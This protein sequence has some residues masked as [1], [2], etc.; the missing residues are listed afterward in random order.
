MAPPPPQS[1]KFVSQDDNEEEDP[2]PTPAA[3]SGPVKRQFTKRQK[4]PKKAY[5]AVLK[6]MFTRD[7]LTV[8]PIDP[9]ILDRHTIVS[10]PPMVSVASRQIRAGVNCVHL[11]HWLF[12][13][14]RVSIDNNTYEFLFDEFKRGCPEGTWNK[15]TLKGDQAL[16]GEGNSNL[17]NW[18]RSIPATAKRFGT[19]LG[20]SDRTIFYDMLT[21]GIPRLVR[22]VRELISV[23]HLLA[24]AYQR[25]KTNS[26]YLELTFKELTSDLLSV[27]PQTFSAYHEHSEVFDFQLEI[28]EAI[29]QNYLSARLSGDSPEPI[30]EPVSPETFRLQDVITQLEKTWDELHNNYVIVETCMFVA[31]TE[32]QRCDKLITTHTTLKAWVKNV[33][34][35]KELVLSKTLITTSPIYTALT[36]AISRKFNVSIQ[37]K[38]KINIRISCEAELKTG[39]RPGREKHCITRVN[40]ATSTPDQGLEED[41]EQEPGQVDSSAPFEEE[42]QDIQHPPKRI[43]DE[44][45]AEEDEEPAG[46][47]EDE[48]P[49]DDENYAPVPDMY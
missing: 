23:T 10:A 31:S 2:S 33:C 35:R 11:V 43:E 29:L 40:K 42:E 49:E 1:P 38:R 34:E 6:A 20:V 19:V 7:W 39:Y 21:V 4:G 12:D 36:D 16:R 15:F 3:P 48:E 27:E 41:E 25:C 22:R 47:E 8:E 44:Y 14:P 13:T 9:T 37:R 45:S 32:I 5:R 17:G 26:G 30:P 46:E 28:L 18:L 24:D